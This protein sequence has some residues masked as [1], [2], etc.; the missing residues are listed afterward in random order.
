MNLT[1]NPYEPPRVEDSTEEVLT[2][3]S[4]AKLI[5]SFLDS[6]I[7]SFQFDEQLEAFDRSD[8][9]IINHVVD[10]VWLHYDDCTDRF[11]CFTKQ[12][13]DYF[14][15]LLLVLS[16]DCRLETESQRHWSIKQLFA[17][18]TLC[19]FVYFAAQF[20]WGEQ[21]LIL[22]IPVGV[23]SI[24]LSFWQHRDTTVANPYAPIIFPFATF[25]DLAKAYHSSGFRKKRYPRHIGERK[26]RSRLTDAFGQIQAY[27]IWL[28]FSPIPLLFQSFPDLQTETRVIAA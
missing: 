24:G 8:D 5:Q 15:R 3:S 1:P 2:R 13:W 23:V 14:Q 22:S 7:T 19:V 6:E 10:A 11:V 9:P 20:G 12:Q 4:L 28:I 26:I 25:S 21:L 17:A 16:S 18:I 27:T